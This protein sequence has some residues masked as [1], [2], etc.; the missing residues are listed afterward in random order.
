[1]SQWLR[2]SEICTLPSWRWRVADTCKSDSQTSCVVCMCD[3]EPRQLVRALTCRHVF[4]SKCV[5]KWLKVSKWRNL[6]KILFTMSYSVADE[7]YLSD[8]SLRIYSSESNDSRLKNFEDRD[9]SPHECHFF[10]NLRSAP[11]Y[12]FIFHLLFIATEFFVF[13]FRYGSGSFV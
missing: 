2:V 7:S 9:C 3:F 5:D 13:S 1:M 4:H 8:L 11:V 6:N 12:I 10:G